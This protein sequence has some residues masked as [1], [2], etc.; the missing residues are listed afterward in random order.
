MITLEKASRSGLGVTGGRGLPGLLC[1][2]LGSSD[3]ACDPRTSR[4]K[5]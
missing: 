1:A 4:P 5:P 2:D 3:S